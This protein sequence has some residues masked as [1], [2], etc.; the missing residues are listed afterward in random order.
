MP[1]IA[2][3]YSTFAKKTDAQR[4]LKRLM[5][6]RLVACGVISSAVESTYFWKGKTPTE[7]EI[8]LMMKTTTV[9]AKRAKAFLASI[10]PY[11]VPCMLSWTADANSAYARWVRKETKR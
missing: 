3:I 10:H 4:S 5:A 1:K 7:K 9:K 2:I 8:V 6:E 11:E